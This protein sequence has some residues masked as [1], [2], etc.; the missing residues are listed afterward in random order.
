MS[1]AHFDLQ[2][3]EGD[4]NEYY[5]EAMFRG[6][7]YRYLVNFD[8]DEQADEFTRRTYRQF[9]VGFEPNMCIWGYINPRDL[10]DEEWDFYR[11][12]LNW[13]HVHNNILRKWIEYRDHESEEFYQR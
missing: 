10:S 1:T 2:Y 3:F 6:S 4:N 12:Q 7:L 5:V 11:S 13:V 8:T 9:S